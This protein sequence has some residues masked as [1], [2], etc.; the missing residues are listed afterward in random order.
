MINVSIFHVFQFVSVIWL[1]LNHYVFVYLLQIFIIIFFNHM[2]IKHPQ[3]CVFCRSDSS[4]Q[5][6]SFNQ[7]FIE[8]CGCSCPVLNVRAY[9]WIWL[10]EKT[11]LKHLYLFYDFWWWKIWKQKLMYAKVFSCSVLTLIWTPKKLPTNY[12]K[13]KN[14][15]H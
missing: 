9:I 13:K 11:L 6:V 2:C 15:Q 8:F 7:F 4:H 10:N 12:T 3:I 14:F 1:E 5:S